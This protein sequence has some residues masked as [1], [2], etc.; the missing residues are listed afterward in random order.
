MTKEFRDLALAVREQQR[1]AGR[2]VNGRA[3]G[4]AL[5]LKGPEADVVVLIDTASFSSQDLYVA[6][7]RGARKI[8]VCSEHSTLMLRG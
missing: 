4:S 5:L 7:S 6:L 8:V 1:V 3:V 2:E